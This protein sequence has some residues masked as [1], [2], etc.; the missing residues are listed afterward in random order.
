MA[1]KMKN[2]V[3]NGKTI[4]AVEKDMENRTNQNNS[5]S[6]TAYIHLK[7]VSFVS[8]IDQII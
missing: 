3:H 2:K 6:N 1:I 8:T 7:F 4:E 5:D